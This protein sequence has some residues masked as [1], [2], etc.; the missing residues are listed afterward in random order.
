VRSLQRKVD[1]LGAANKGYVWGD[2]EENNIYSSEPEAEKREFLRQIC[3]TWRS[4]T[5]LDIG[6]S[7][8][9]FSLLAAEQDATV[10][11]LDNNMASLDRLYRSA[12]KSHASVLPLRLDISNPSPGIGCRVRWT[13]KFGQVAK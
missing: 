2:Y 8:R 1:G 13:R 7:T 5:G 11:A 3:E 6:C 9:I 12:N 10:V 4:E